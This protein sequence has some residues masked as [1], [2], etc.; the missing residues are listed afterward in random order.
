MSDTEIFLGGDQ[1]VD[2]VRER[3]V[4]VAWLAVCVHGWLDTPACEGRCSDGG[5]CRTKGVSGDDE[6]RVA[7]GHFF[8]DGGNGGGRDSVVGSLEALVDLYSNID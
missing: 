7:V 1:P 3:R 8:L 2:V 6:R 4:A 5:N